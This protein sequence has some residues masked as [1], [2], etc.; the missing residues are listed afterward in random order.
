M[1]C[2]HTVGCQKVASTFAFHPLSVFGTPHLSGTFPGSFKRLQKKKQTTQ[3]GPLPSSS[4]ASA[5]R[6]LN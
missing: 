2:E 4:E 6:C 1:E 3:H 5:L